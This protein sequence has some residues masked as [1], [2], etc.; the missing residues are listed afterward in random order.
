MNARFWHDGRWWDTQPKVL[1][2]MDHAMWMSSSV[3]DGA[4]IFAGLAPD[5]DRHCE[6]LIDSAQKM[7]LQP[8]HSAEAV[9]A[10][11]VE[12]FKQMPSDKA[13]YVRPM[14]YATRGFVA[15]EPESTAFLLAVYEAPMPAPDGFSVTAAPFRR[16]A[17][18]AAPVDAKAGCNYPNGQRALVWA[19]RRGFDNALILDPA[20]NVAE[21]ATAN[22]WVA[23]D[24][25]AMTPAWNGTF[26]NGI[27]KQRVAELLVLD[28][29]D[30]LETTLT[31]E[32]F[33]E[34]DEIFSTG[35]YGKVMPCIRYEKRELQPGPIYRR[36][37]ELYFDYA[38]REPAR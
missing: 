1:G 3:F 29:I 16:P 12:A 17:R 2:P 5:L 30:V 10:L 36:A 37:R 9:Q 31:L 18:D 13:Y 35:N 21:L 20:A 28:G 27:T 11:A 23:K 24:G 6:R 7:L 33:D 15:P 26:L 22:I 8:T 34:A 25:V 14:F 4:R 19:R 38:M 32:D